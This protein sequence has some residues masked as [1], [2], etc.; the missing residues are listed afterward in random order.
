MA[1]VQQHVAPIYVV[2][3]KPAIPTVLSPVST[4]SKPDIHPTSQPGLYPTPLQTYI[5]RIS[6]AKG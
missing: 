1:H 5:R 3:P 4:N 6:E 2:N